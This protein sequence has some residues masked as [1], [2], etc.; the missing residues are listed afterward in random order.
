MGGSPWLPLLTCNNDS[1]TAPDTF[2]QAQTIRIAIALTALKYKPANI[3]IRQYVV[4][5][6]RQ[7][8]LSCVE[9]ELGE[10][11]NRDHVIELETKLSEVQAT[12]EAQYIEL[13]ALRAVAVAAKE[14][15]S[16]PTVPPAVPT[17]AKRK[18]AKKPGVENGPQNT[19]QD[20]VA[21]IP[22]PVKA[23]TVASTSTEHALLPALRAL[24]A[25]SSAISNPF[26]SSPPP[27]LLLASAS[28]CIESLGSIFVSS[29][30]H[31]AAARS[32]AGSGFSPPE[33]Q[34]IV[35]RVLPHVLSTVLPPLLNSF[36]RS[37]SI[38]LQKGN[39]WPLDASLGL[40]SVDNDL[41]TALDA[42]F[43]SALELILLPA[44]RAFAPMT[45]A[46]VGHCLQ[47]STPIPRSQTQSVAPL[48][49]ASL[50]GLVASTIDTLADLCSDAQPPA[51]ARDKALLAC[52]QA[53]R[54]RVALEAVRELTR[55]FSGE[56]EAQSTESRIIRLAR[57]DTLHRLC[58]AASLSLHR[59]SEPSSIL[60]EALGEALGEL[61]RMPTKSAM[62]EVEEAIMLAVVERAWAVGVVLSGK[63]HAE[64]RDVEM[65]AG[66]ED[67]S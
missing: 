46:H 15:P 27:S 45:A 32:A 51:S 18:R 61:V 63:S 65:S 67:K 14:T 41:S 30:A 56:A 3:S 29:R 25:L 4:D 8:C 52:V 39:A 48:S 31:D 58:A 1:M 20:L 47:P 53:V 43:G 22:T 36:K 62:D 42:I 60:R 9:V 50:L 11:Q 12:S 44:V 21:A 16:A 35:T 49:P 24:F 6:Q 64:D 66:D 10:D 17:A 28:R 2:D 40:P 19:A 5:L 38:K 13:L 54:D 34:N 33:A 7:F 57:K 23:S 26:S 55:L 59:A 37:G